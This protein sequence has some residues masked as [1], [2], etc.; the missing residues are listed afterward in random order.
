MVDTERMRAVLERI[1]PGPPPF[2]PGPPAAP[3]PGP[4]PPRPR[5]LPPPVR[6]PVEWLRQEERLTEILRRIGRKS[7]ALRRRMAQLTEASL[8]RQRILRRWTGG[9]L[10]IPPQKWPGT[11]SD[12]LRR[13]EMLAGELKETYR[14]AAEER[15]GAQESYRDLARSAAETERGLREILRRLEY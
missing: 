1:R 15:A 14:R 7:P 8:R 6:G 5:P 9:S 12:L 13:G 11:L 2:P 10:P 4:P 3:T